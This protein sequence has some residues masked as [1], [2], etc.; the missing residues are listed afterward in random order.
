MKSDRSKQD[1][2]IE[3]PPHV[4]GPYGEMYLRALWRTLEGGTEDPTQEG[5]WAPSERSI[6]EAYIRR[7]QQGR[8]EGPIGTASRYSVGHLEIF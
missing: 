3:E 6:G 7:L 1:T 8:L 2:W 4:G 5:V